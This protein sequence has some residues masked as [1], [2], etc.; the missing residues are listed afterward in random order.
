MTSLVKF[1]SRSIG[2]F[3]GT[4]IFMAL[5]NVFTWRHTQTSA[6]RT[7]SPRHV[8]GAGW[9]IHVLVDSVTVWVLRRKIAV[10][11]FNH[12]LR[13]CLHAIYLIFLLPRRSCGRDLSARFRQFLAGESGIGETLPEH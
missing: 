10:S 1:D 2:V 11:P 3:P 5:V 9:V 7:N 4:I 6:P 8:R 12:R 13:I